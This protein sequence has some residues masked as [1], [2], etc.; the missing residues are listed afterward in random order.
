MKIRWTTHLLLFLLA[1]CCLD[2]QVQHFW[3]SGKAADRY[4]P[5][6]PDVTK[7]AG[8]RSRE[9]SLLAA[10]LYQSAW[11]FYYKTQYDSLAQVCHQLFPL[12]EHLLEQGYDSTT[13]EYWGMGYSGYGMA[14]M[15]LGDIEEGSR[16]L[17]EFDSIDRRVYPKDYIARSMFYF[18]LG[19]MARDLF[20]DYDLALE[21]YKL[22]QAVAQNCLAKD[23]RFFINVNLVLGC[24]YGQIG[25]YATQSKYF[26][27]ILVM[28]PR[29]RQ[30]LP[31]YIALNYQNAGDYEN[32]IRYRNLANEQTPAPLSVY[33]QNCELTECYLMVGD[34]AN[35]R[36]CLRICEELFYRHQAEIRTRDIGASYFYAKAV[37]QTAMKQYPEAIAGFRKSLA[38][39]ESS[40]G[41]K[42]SNLSFTIFHKLAE[43]LLLADS[44]PGA[45]AAV[46][47]LLAREAGG[48]QSADFTRNP[49]LKTFSRQPYHLR[50]LELKGRCFEK[51]FDHTGDPAH[52]QHALQT[53]ALADS[54]IDNIRDTYRGTG[55]KN[56]F[57]GKAK[58]IFQRS[59]HCAYRL[60]QRNGDPQFLSRAWQAAEKSK[61]VAL[62]ESLRESE[63]KQLAGFRPE[64]L[65]H[66]K[67]L[68][69]DLDFYEK[70]SFDEQAKPQPDTLRLFRWN[71]NIFNLKA[72]QDSLLLVFR[73]RYPEYHRLKYDRRIA[74]VAEVQAQL[75]AGNALVEYF[76][77]DSVLFTFL[78]EKGQVQLFQQ[79]TDSSWLHH[80]AALRAT[81]HE[82]DPAILQTGQQKANDFQRFARSSHALYRLLLAEPL[83]HSKAQRL[84]IVPDD[85]IGYVPFAALLQRPVEAS[86]TPDYRH[87]PYL[88][89]D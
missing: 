48:F 2:F 14:L 49:P 22:G 67:R 87:L 32:A 9:D 28:D 46:Q 23:D 24:F 89:R 7:Q 13:F 77:G 12:A 63:A 60:W 18:G 30:V 35:S 51:M 26:D 17:V 59:I 11:K 76:L 47:E 41:G 85:Q 55:S 31:H 57:S 39:S 82:F 40:G 88:V 65:A 1:A 16:I 58:A 79:K 3:G 78:L 21:Y 6:F 81:V 20:K 52:L 19:H 74:T 68:K 84:V 15:Y 69:R 29:M 86:A 43:T 66:E 62:L 75:P 54:L 73:Q 72:T 70:F 64:D 83:A 4:P 53:Y 34:L 38:A 36:R 27:K 10:G 50:T 45:Q 56:E 37:F 5:E 8:T 25:D 44:L 61:A 42:Q 71:R 80:F 33:Y